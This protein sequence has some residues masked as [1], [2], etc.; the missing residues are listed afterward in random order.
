[1]TICGLDNAG[2]TTIVNYLMTGEFTETEPTMGANRETLDLPKLQLGIIDLGGQEDFRGMWSEV[3][4]KTNSFV[5]VVD[6]T[7]Q[8]RLDETKEIFHNI[9]NTQL[10]ENVPTLILLH[11]VDLENRITRADFVEHF[12]LASLKFKWRCF[13]TSAK[14]GYGIYPSFKWLVNELGG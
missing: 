7:D 14:T 11:K 13:E 5:Y 4:E 9:V 6:S 3:N 2:K 10:N 12:E 8:Q 1:M